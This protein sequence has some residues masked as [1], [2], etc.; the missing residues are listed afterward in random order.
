MES[1]D[2][3]V[4]DGESESDVWISRIGKQR[5]IQYLRC[6]GGGSRLRCRR[7]KDG[8]VEVVILDVE[9]D[10]VTQIVNLVNIKFTIV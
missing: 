8:G 3:T 2:L 1:T 6:Q 9:E 10:I 7:G 4:E 5:S